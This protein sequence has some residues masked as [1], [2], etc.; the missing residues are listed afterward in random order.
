MRRRTSNVFGSLRSQRS[1]RSVEDGG[2]DNNSSRRHS[3]V[4]SVDED[5]WRNSSVVIH[6]GD[7]QTTGGMW[8]RRSQY[9]VLTNTHLIRFKSQSKA[10]DVFPSIVANCSSSR[11]H[12]QQPPLNNRQSSIS[13]AANSIQDSTNAY[14]D[15]AAAIPLHSII[16]IY[17]LEDTGR[18]GATTTTVELAYLDERAHKA[19]LI[20]MHTPDAQDLNMW[21]AGIRS[22]AQLAR[23]ANPLPIDQT[24]IDSVVNVL[25]HERDYDPSTFRI[26]RVL[27]MASTKSSAGSSDDLTKVS[28]TGCYLAIGSHKLHLISFQKA[29]SGTGAT[30][31]EASSS[32]FGLMALTSLSMEWGD[33]SLHL[34]FR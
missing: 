32:S 34:T 18:A 23:S 29:A 30:D 31:L 7:V 14:G 24:S 27:Q 33:D 17:L 8:R 19:A 6:H 5:E 25:E 10:V 1:Q 12:H 15:A 22:A 26:F 4:S 28:P 11:S 3:K 2:G 21:M 9:L 16:A 20:Q 13:I